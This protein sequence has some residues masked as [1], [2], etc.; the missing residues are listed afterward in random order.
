MS[1]IKRG[2]WTGHAAWRKK[3]YRNLVQNPLREAPLRTSRRMRQ[4]D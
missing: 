4:H 2:H 3:V 1:E